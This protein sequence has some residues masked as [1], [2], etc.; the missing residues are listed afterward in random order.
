M[1]CLNLDP[2][3]TLSQNCVSIFS[4][5]LTSIFSK[6]TTI[7]IFHRFNQFVNKFSRNSLKNDAFE[8]HFGF[9][10]NFRS[11]FEYFKNGLTTAEIKK[12][13]LQS[14]ELPHFSCSYSQ[15]KQFHSNLLC[16]LSHP[17]NDS[18]TQLASQEFGFVSIKV[19]LILE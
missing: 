17:L 14:F 19:Q 4:T 12:Q 1:F 13:R 18:F 9:A 2:Q 16:L 5:I 15:T 3:I 7:Y 6:T 11:C 10:S 8:S